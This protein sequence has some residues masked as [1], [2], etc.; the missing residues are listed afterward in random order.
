MQSEAL[1]MVRRLELVCSWLMLNIMGCFHQDPIRYVIDLIGAK[2]TG[3]SPDD[4][5]ASRLRIKY[6]ITM[7]GTI[8]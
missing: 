2:C 7:R 6:S 1:G 5:D 8:I 3:A 4:Y